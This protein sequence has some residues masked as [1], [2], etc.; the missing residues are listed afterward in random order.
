VDKLPNALWSLRKPSA[1]FVA[2][3]WPST[4]FARCA[5]GCLAGGAPGRPRPRAALGLWFQQ[6]VCLPGIWQGM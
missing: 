6:A 1:F 4:F 2:S 3:C 5:S